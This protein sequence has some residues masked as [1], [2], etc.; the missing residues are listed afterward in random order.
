VLAVLFC[1]ILVVLLVF[2]V[3]FCVI[4]VV[5]LVLAVPVLCNFSC[6]LSVGGAVFVYFYLYS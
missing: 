4:L 1:V 5:L 6:T 2:A 3:L